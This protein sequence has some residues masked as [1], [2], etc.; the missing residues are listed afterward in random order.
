MLVFN[1]YVDASHLTEHAQCPSI[2]VVFAP[3]VNGCVCKLLVTDFRS[4][5]FHVAVMAVEATEIHF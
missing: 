2:F 3:Y 4:I 5:I 1:V